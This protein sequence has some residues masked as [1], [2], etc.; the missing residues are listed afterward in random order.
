[1][2]IC[3]DN[4]SKSIEVVEQKE[5]DYQRRVEKYI[6]EHSNTLK[7]RRKACENNLEKIKLINLPFYLTK[8]PD[9]NYV[10]QPHDI[11]RFYDLSQKLLISLKLRDYLEPCLLKT[12]L[13]ENIWKY[14]NRATQNA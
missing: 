4:L 9:W 7:E 1:M 6:R 2:K 14:S 12:P 13:L 10:Y 11:H 3:I 5:N 8:N